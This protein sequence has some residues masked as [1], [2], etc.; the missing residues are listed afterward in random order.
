MRDDG[1]P[2]AEL[3]GRRA[4][5]TG[6]AEGIGRAIAA[7]LAKRGVSVAVA[8]IDVEAAQRTAAQIG[9]SA[10]AVE[11]DVRRRDSVEEAFA[12][13]IERLGGCEILIANAGV[14]TM[15]HAL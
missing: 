2:Y 1:S 12:A 3:Q 13:A 4:F 11:I 6:G 7:A 9:E 15:Q 8:D 10:V 5:V 14:S